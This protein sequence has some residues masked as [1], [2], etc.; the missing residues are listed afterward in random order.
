[1]R[2]EVPGRDV[3]VIADIVISHIEVGVLVSDR[4]ADE[5]MIAIEKPDEGLWRFKDENVIRRSESPEIWF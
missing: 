3:Q 2:V 1:V 5:L 4:L